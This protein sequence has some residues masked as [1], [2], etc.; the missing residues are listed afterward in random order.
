[1][2]RDRGFHPLHIG[3]TLRGEQPTDPELLVFDKI[4]HGTTSTVWLC[5]NALDNVW[6]AV[7]V[8]SARDSRLRKLRGIAKKQYPPELRALIEL[9]DMDTRKTHVVTPT[10]HFWIEGP[11]GRH[12]C[13]TMPL[14]GP[15][16][17]YAIEKTNN[18]PLAKELLFQVAKGI[19]FLRSCH[20][21]H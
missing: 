15:S 5:R 18:L 12:L 4:G 6:C 19:A 9:K 13:L 8:V 2:Y 7:K 3:D 11:N 10:N 16:I 17:R 1:M 20:I 21:C 14:L